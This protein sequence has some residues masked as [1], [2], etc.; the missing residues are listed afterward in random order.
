VLSA[1][2]VV[3]KLVYAAELRIDV[4]AVLAAAADTVLVA[5][6]LRNLVPIW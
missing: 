4:A 3:V 2:G 6:H 1:R 5:K